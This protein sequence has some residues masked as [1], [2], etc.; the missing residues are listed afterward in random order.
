MTQAIE[1]ARSGKPGSRAVTASARVFNRKQSSPDGLFID[2]QL[3]CAA[4]HHAKHVTVGKHARVQAD[5]QANSVV[6]SGQ[7][8]GNIYS[9]GKVSLDSYSRVTGNIVCAGIV[10]A[11]G[12]RFTGRIDMEKLTNV[13]SMSDTLVTGETIRAQKIRPHIAKPGIYA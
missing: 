1:R 8:I 11:D 9:T 2:G 6:I 7:L 12:A 4:V 13:A 3:D 10:I 5:I